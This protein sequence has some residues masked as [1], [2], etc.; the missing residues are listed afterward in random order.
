MPRSFNQERRR[1][2]S[3]RDH[4]ELMMDFDFGMGEACHMIEGRRILHCCHDPANQCWTCFKSKKVLG[5]D[6]VDA[7]AGLDFAHNQMYVYS[8]DLC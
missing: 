2:T 8:F 4:S 5:H 6:R 1:Y 3:Q 7:R